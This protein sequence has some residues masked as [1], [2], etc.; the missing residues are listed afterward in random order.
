M[1]LNNAFVLRVKSC[2]QL[3]CAGFLTAGVA[4]FRLH[5]MEL[6]NLM[7][8]FSLPGPG[9][10]TSFFLAGPGPL[11]STSS[12]SGPGLLACFSLAGVS[13]HVVST[14]FSSSLLTTDYGRGEGYL[15]EA[16]SI[17][18]KYQFWEEQIL[19]AGI[20]HLMV[21]LQASLSAI[22]IHMTMSF[23]M[24]LFIAL[25]GLKLQYL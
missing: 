22:I 14:F 9:L 21:Y 12:L 20:L 3:P 13:A 2:F 11:A 16:G 8:F 25:L 6:G 18:F 1:D 7:C 4:V 24:Q 15:I 10:L 5:E 17:Y 19:G 23:I